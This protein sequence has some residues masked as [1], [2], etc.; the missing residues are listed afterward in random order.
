MSSEVVGGTKEL[1][2]WRAVRRKRKNG[3]RVPWSP[4]TSKTQKMGGMQREGRQ[5][6][7][8]LLMRGA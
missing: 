3:G 1:A 6:A 7:F 8:T 4:P 2:M 5:K